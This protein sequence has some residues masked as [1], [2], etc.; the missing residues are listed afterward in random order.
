MK[1]QHH[2]PLMKIQAFQFHQ[3][4]LSLREK[5]T[6]LLFFCSEIFIIPALALADLSICEWHGGSWRKSVSGH[7][8]RVMDCDGECQS[9]P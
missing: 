8:V 2:C 9:A 3:V 1:E 5:R 6:P 7:K 4:P